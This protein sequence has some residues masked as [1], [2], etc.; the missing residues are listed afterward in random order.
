H[1]RGNNARR[2]STIAVKGFSGTAPVAQTHCLGLGMCNRFPQPLRPYSLVAARTVRKPPFARGHG[3][4]RGASCP[5]A[6][7]PRSDLA[8]RPQ[9]VPCRWGTA[10]ATTRA[11]RPIAPAWQDPRAPWYAFA[12]RA[13]RD[14]AG[15][16]GGRRAAGLGGGKLLA[17]THTPYSQNIRTRLPA[18]D[19]APTIAYTSACFPPSDHGYSPA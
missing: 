19:Y 7:C 5:R 15:P 18:G 4:R 6:P 2:H 17:S 13:R 14:A 8:A 16:H 9:V 12:R 3:Q 1:V 11:W 10:Q